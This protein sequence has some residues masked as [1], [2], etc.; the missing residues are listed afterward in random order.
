MTSDILG[1]F[2]HYAR[3]HGLT[4]TLWRILVGTGRTLRGTRLI[5]F[6]CD[7][8]SL[9][10]AEVARPTGRTIERKS[11]VTDLDPE[12]LARV[13][14]VGYA[15]VVRRQ[16][17]KRFAQG[18]SLW[19]CRVES[20][21]A[22]Y[23]WTLTGQTMVPHFFP[24]CP[25]DVHL[26]DFYVF[27]EFRGQRL[28]PSLVMQILKTL[29]AESKGRAFIEAAE[30]NAPQ[31]HSVAKMPFQKLGYARKYCFFGRTIVIWSGGPVSAGSS[32]GKP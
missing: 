27:P 32:G 29:A 7:L 15:K 24:L 25:G 31:L 30:W 20:Q 23:G 26:F 8:G 28:N 3:R 19:L 17:S 9:E 11:A 1:R 13:E 12:D 14:N 21:V 4:A 16:I 6:G 22:A 18:A 2:A 10:A 5:L